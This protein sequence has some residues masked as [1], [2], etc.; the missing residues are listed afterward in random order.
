MR[1]G[2]TGCPFSSWGVNGRAAHRHSVDTLIK[3]GGVEC[4]LL[5]VTKKSG[6]RWRYSLC[7]GLGLVIDSVKYLL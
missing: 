4:S 3:C 2:L 6:A 5:L 1:Y 7:R